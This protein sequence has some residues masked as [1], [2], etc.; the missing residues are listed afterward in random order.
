MD[1]KL[2]SVSEDLASAL[3]EAM[4]SLL[5]D[6]DVSELWVVEQGA[7]LCTRRGKKETLPVEIERNI[8]KLLKE[9]LGERPSL[10]FRLADGHVV[11]VLASA[12]RN[13]GLGFNVEMRPSRLSTLSDLVE[14]D[15]VSA[16]LATELADFI[17]RGEGVIVVG[18][19][20]G[21]RI[22]LAG[23]LAQ[24]AAGLFRTTQVDDG[25]L[26]EG[27]RPLPLDLQAAP[28]ERVAAARA[29][30]V[31]TFFDPNLTRAGLEKTYDS[32]TGLMVIGAL[33]TPNLRALFGQLG[34]TWKSGQDLIPWPHALVGVA[35]AAIQVG[36]DNAGF[37]AVVD[38]LFLEG[39]RPLGATQ[40]APQAAA[41]RA[42]PSPV[43]PSSP[44]VATVPAL[45]PGSS[46][47][48]VYAPE[49][50]VE[51]G[52]P[53]L[54]PPSG[55][56][57]GKEDL[58]PGWELGDVPTDL[59]NDIPIPEGIEDLAAE[60]PDDQNDDD[61]E[62]AYDDESLASPGAVGQSPGFEGALERARR[63]QKPTFVPHPPPVHPQTHKL[64]ADPFGG[65]TL[66]PPSAGQD[67][68]PG[69]EGAGAGGDKK[70]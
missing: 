30:G 27:L 58:G 53:P 37:P 52:P 57:P 18:Q 64:Q 35:S 23:A 19:P 66:E 20:R 69:D 16:S 3:T 21:I 44:P 36:F 34:V 62:V 56:S 33:D 63:D 5:A 31:E 24:I 29:V 7:P 6:A 68:G 22:R 4:G 55:W 14:E 65:L 67:D 43:L 47:V 15:L 70:S 60:H 61:D 9:A 59:E 41:P 2:D 51:A 17:R 42:M 45:S 26:W 25:P 13:Q 10:R 39:G 11:Q 54:A 50:E 48:Q 12:G 49:P 1:R 40:M 46:A 8:F 38:H 28:A 32:T